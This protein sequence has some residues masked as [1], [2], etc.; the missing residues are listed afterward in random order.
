M[1]SQ[2]LTQT[3]WLQVDLLNAPLSCGQAPGP[4]GVLRYMLYF[5]KPLRLSLK[6]LHSCCW[7]PA[8]SKVSLSSHWACSLSLTP[9]WG[10]PEHF[11]TLLPGSTYLPI[12]TAMAAPASAPPA[13]PS[14]FHQRWGLCTVGRHKSVTPRVPQGQGPELAGVSVCVRVCWKEE[15]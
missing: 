9:A 1:R 7:H 2:D 13:F 12:T 11:L 10:R 4:A 15:R 8:F 14:E 6:Q 5:S 3:L